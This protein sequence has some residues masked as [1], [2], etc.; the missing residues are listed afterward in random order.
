MEKV[1]KIS[2][3]YFGFLSLAFGFGLIGP[4]LPELQR[5]TDS[6]TQTISWVVTAR[7][8]GQLIGSLLAGFT[9]EKLPVGWVCS[10][11]MLLVAPCTVMIPFLRNIIVMCIVSGVWGIASSFCIV[12]I[13]LEILHMWLGRGPGPWMQALHSIYNVRM[14]LS[15][16][17]AQPFLS[18]SSDMEQNT[19]VSNN[20]SLEHLGE[21]YKNINISSNLTILWW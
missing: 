7:S 8:L 13:N 2:V 11:A 10:V 1:I 12:A 16:I 17:L 3:A 5:L 14:L 4:T 9:L 20:K 15:P 18:N 6:D 19:T 21:T